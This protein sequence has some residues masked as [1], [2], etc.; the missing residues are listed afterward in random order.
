MV[1]YLG[2][3]ILKEGLKTYFKK[4]KFKNTEMSDF[5]SELSD[6]AVRLGL[7]INFREWSDSWLTTAGC[8]EIGL[9]FDKDQS[10]G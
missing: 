5:I 1:F 9:K 4:Y 8:A 6:A 2:K 7:T 10:T 3:D